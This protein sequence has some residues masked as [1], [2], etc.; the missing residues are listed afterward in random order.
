M[1][2]LPDEDDET[3]EVFSSP[4]SAPPIEPV[5]EVPFYPQERPVEDT[6]A[7]ETADQETPAA[8]PDPANEDPAPVPAPELASEEPSATAAAA[9]ENVVVLPLPE[10]EKRR[11]SFEKQAEDSFR[12]G[13]AHQSRRMLQPEFG[14]NDAE[15]K[16]GAKARER[17][18][19]VS[20]LS[21]N[22]ETVDSIVSAAG[23]AC[24]TVAI[25]MR[26]ST[27]EW[28]TGLTRINTRLFEFGQLNAQNGMDFMRA[29]SGVRTVR[30][31]MDVQTAYL[32]GQYDAMASQLRELQTLTTEVAGKT[33]QPFKDQFT[34]AAQLG[35]MC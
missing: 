3:I 18:E 11:Q 30:D 20:A 9:N 27:E 33:A 15:Q 13:L 26:S 6:P 16:A 29:I 32:R 8:V 21:G 34:R 17:S 4:C 28:M 31:A 7:Q 19:G 14:K 5:P 1:I 35:R 10:P 2:H 23:E 22:S 12:M 25:A 24:Q